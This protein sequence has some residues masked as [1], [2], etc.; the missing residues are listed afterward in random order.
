TDEPG[1]PGTDAEPTG[2]TGK[3]EQ[4][5]PEDRVL[6]WNETWTYADH[7]VIHEDSPILYYSHAADRKGI[8]VSV[9]AGHGT[10]GGN[11]VKTLCHP[12][13]TAKVTGGS[14]SAGE[15][16]AAAV[17]SGTTFL[18]GTT[19]GEANLTLA[20]LLKGM[21]LEEGYDV[22]MIREDNDTQLD[23][24]ARTVYSN[25][26]ADCHIAIH[27]DSSESDKGFFYIGVPDIASY[28]AMEPVA[29]HWKSHNALGEA[30]LEGVKSAGVK[31]CGNGNIPLDLTQTSY[32]TIPSIDVEVG[33]RKSDHSESTQREIARGLVAGVNIFFEGDGLA[34]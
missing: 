10:P 30:L 12:D 14:T 13:G 29:S 6:E 22:L 8:V 1:I 18:D 20:V 2:E 15:T 23:N 17:S 11:K 26:Y 4:D 34:D 3:E 19:E 16:K 25:N 27:Y 5:I 7:S 24:I 28:R 31:I 33:D 32:S 9:N 21:L